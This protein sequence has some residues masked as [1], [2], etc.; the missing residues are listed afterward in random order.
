MRLLE[1]LPWLLL[2]ALV[3]FALNLLAQKIFPTK[4]GDPYDRR[5][6]YR[7]VVYFMFAVALGAAIFIGFALDR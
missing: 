1:R 2:L 7:M 3:I 5:V 4:A 6:A